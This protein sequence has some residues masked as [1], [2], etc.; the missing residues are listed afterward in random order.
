MKRA[1]ARRSATSEVR[2]PQN[3]FEDFGTSKLSAGTATVSL[4]VTFA[5][6]VNTNMSYHVFLTPKGNCRGLYVT[7]ETSRGFEVRELRGGK[8]NVQFDYRIFARRKGFEAI[9]PADMTAEPNST[10]ARTGVSEAAFQ[11]AARFSPSR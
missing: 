9:R 4:D 3:W 10:H 1:R 5:Q 6:T 11:P 2:P 7:K 8:S